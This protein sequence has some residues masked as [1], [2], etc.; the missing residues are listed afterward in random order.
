MCVRDV[1]ESF[2]TSDRRLP[3]C[4]MHLALRSTSRI[5]TST[6]TGDLGFSEVKQIHSFFEANLYKGVSDTVKSVVEMAIRQNGRRHKMR[7]RKKLSRK[8]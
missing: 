1:N 2:A 6:F 3:D 5:V 8:L 7:T 4:H